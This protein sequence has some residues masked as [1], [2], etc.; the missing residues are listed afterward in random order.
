MMRY[1]VF[2]AAL[3]AACSAPVPVAIPGAEPIPANLPRA[4]VGKGDPSALRATLAKRF[5]ERKLAA[6]SPPVPQP[7]QT[8]TDRQ[9]SVTIVGHYG[10]AQTR[11]K[12]WIVHVPATGCTVTA[13]ASS[14][15]PVSGAWNIPGDNNADIHGQSFTMPYA[16]V[17]TD[18]LVVTSGNLGE[19]YAS[20]VPFRFAPTGSAVD[21]SMA[22]VFVPYAVDSS[23]LRPP[24]FGGNA[25]PRWFRTVPMPESMVDLSKL[26]NTIDI[27]SLGINWGPTGW[28][29]TDLV[30]QCLRLYGG[31]TLAPPATPAEI[32][33]AR[34]GRFCGDFFTGWGLTS[35][36][37]PWLQHQGYGTFYAGGQS[38]SF[39]VL[40]SKIEVEQKRELAMCLVQNALDQIGA[41][42]D[43]PN[44][45]VTYPLG[46]H[47]W[48]RKFQ[49]VM[50]GHLMGIPEF[51]NI[52][53]HVG[54]LFAE[55]TGFSEGTWWWGS[56]P[57]Q[58]KSQWH[59]DLSFPHN[60]LSTHPSTWPSNFVTLISYMGQV[61][62][63]HIGTALAA[64]LMG[65]SDGLNP[66]LV[67]MVAQHVAGP[68]AQAIADMNAAG[69]GP[70]HWGTDYAVPAGLA[71][72]AWHAYYTP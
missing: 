32:A 53:D 5:P 24:A 67:K 64:D 12:S 1:I 69:C 40:C 20:G 18:A 65:L 35:S 49:V 22:V 13:I 31:Q 57:G 16:V 39:I 2:L 17:P 45:R 50:A 28:S 21:E 46:G 27:E 14:S 63:A 68:S 42:T 36:R 62:P 11:D 72:A 29:G 47:C 54:E 58:W 43:A 34:A 30:G 60:I 7:S 59:F 25:T 51:V 4:A 10:A 66:D 33:Y 6:M 26:P 56:G 9:L 38:T 37:V 70:Q 44:A 3:F 52:S 55:D 41:F 71:V 23:L 61:C 8:L 19:A 48:G 15:G